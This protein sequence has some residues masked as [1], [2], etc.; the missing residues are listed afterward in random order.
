MKKDKDMKPNHADPKSTEAS[1]ARA[2]VQVPEVQGPVAAGQRRNWLQRLFGRGET[3][4]RQVAVLQQGYLEL[5]D[6]MR[7]IRQHLAAQEEAQRRLAGQLEH[8][9]AAVDGLKSI[10]VA[11]QQQNE[12]FGLLKQRFESSARHDQ[13]LTDSMNQFRQ[14]LTMMDETN[15]T[16]AQTISEL[17]ERTWEAEELARS[18]LIRSQRRFAF[19][20][21]VLLLVAL[22]LAGS[23]F[24][25]FADSGR[26][27]KVR[28]LPTLQW[29]RDVL[30]AP[31]GHVRPN[32][33]GAPA[34]LPAP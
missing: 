32:P 29:A 11:A 26:L 5:L 34:Q 13:Q 23:G 9:P 27:E 14:T 17:A 4:D 1:V 25:L 6:L 8:L 22:L 24:Y 33:P 3:R 15:R 31:P 2:T 10:G 18:V 16:T 12:I 30:F 21:V 28:S 20:A 19:L 7:G